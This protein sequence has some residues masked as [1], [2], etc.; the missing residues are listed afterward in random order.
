VC[1]K[2]FLLRKNLI[3]HMKNIHKVAPHTFPTAAAS[4][5][6]PLTPNSRTEAEEVSSC[7]CCAKTFYY[8]SDRVNHEALHAGIRSHACDLCAKSYCTA[9]SLKKHRQVAHLSSAA[10]C[11]CPVCHKVLSTRLK[12]RAHRL[13]HSSLRPFACRQCGQRFKEKRSLLKHIK[14]KKHGGGEG[15]APGGALVHGEGEEG[16]EK[17]QFASKDRDAEQ[18]DSTEFKYNSS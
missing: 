7:R 16:V 2:N 14:L 5:P 3:R 10:D 15:G 1:Q 12:L 11:T 6:L 8:K 9:K 13:T 4:S 18:P 17:A